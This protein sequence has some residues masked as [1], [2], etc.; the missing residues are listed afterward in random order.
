VLTLHW[1]TIDM[2]PTTRC[3]YLQATRPDTAK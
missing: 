2:D 3:Y 1:Q